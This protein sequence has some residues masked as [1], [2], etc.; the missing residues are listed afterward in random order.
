M[1]KK[2]KYSLVTSAVMLALQ[3]QG[4]AEEAETIAKKE[5]EVEVIVVTSQKRLQRLIDVPISV[6][7]VGSKELEQRGIKQL[8]DI[9]ETAPN[10]NMSESIDFRSK[11]TIRGV[12]ANSRNIGFDS[13]VGIYIDGVYL[14]QSP[15][16][17]QG[18]VDLER[19]EVLRG[20]QGTL[21]GKNTIAGAINLI[22]Q[23]PIDEFEGSVT[24]NIGNF[25]VRDYHV[26]LNLPLGDST[27]AKVFLNRSEGGSYVKNT[28]TGRD[29]G[30]KDAMAGRINLVSELSSALEFTWS[31][32]YANSDNYILNGSPLTD[33]FGY[34]PAAGPFTTLLPQEFIDSVDKKFEIYQPRDAKEDKTVWGTSAIFDYT[35][36]NNFALKSITAYRDTEM[37]VR[38]PT[39]L[40]PLDILHVD[41][42]DAYK[43]TTQEFQLISPDQGDFKYILGAYY[44]SQ[45]SSTVRDAI[46]AA[47]GAILGLSP[48]VAVAVDG[49]VETTSYALFANGTYDLNADW[50]LGFGLR[51]SSE[52]KEVDWDIDGSR[53]GIFRMATANVTDDR[54]DNYVSPA[55][56]ISYAVSPDAQLYARYSTGFKS[57]GY[58]L[59]FVTDDVLEAGIEFDKETV[60]SYEIGYKTQLIDYGLNFNSSIFYSEYEDYQVNQYVDLGG[61]RTAISITNAAAVI[62]QGVELEFDYQMTDDFAI[63]GSLGYLDATF[64]SFP[65]GGTGGSDAS[66]NYLP[67]AP[68][69]TASLSLE[70]FQE[71]S[72]LDATMQYRLDYNYTDEQYYL[73]NNDE[74]YVVPI[75]GKVVDFDKADSYSSVNARITLMSNEDT[76]Q[77]ALWGRNLNDS[78]HMIESYR[79]FFGGINAIYARPRSYGVEVKYNF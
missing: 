18:L 24:A 5:K 51:Y 61:G 67:N 60:D 49:D 47:G 9:S 58:N 55:I 10:L 3:G 66:G 32:D 75:T 79:E 46:A 20:P 64:D 38:L 13:R 72:S 62:T 17:N 23:K 1:N 16:L 26:K 33:P 71:I 31:A 21:F 63:T 40:S 36:A 45:D 42:T 35:M 69:W 8:Q 25:D 12:G 78:D 6:T 29:V 44:F 53:S 11:V 19:V 73:V 59:D 2:I 74:N 28:M 52:K 43:Q 34:D 57:G 68:E 56:N 37:R 76:W 65:G 50:Q 48:G 7:S 39:D 15:A 41:Y 54:T 30:D 14:G 77:V 70:Y 4:F 22:S 27:A